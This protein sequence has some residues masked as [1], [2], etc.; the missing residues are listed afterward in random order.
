MV[1]SLSDKGKTHDL[2]FLLK[3]KNVYLEESGTLIF[4]SKEHIYLK[5]KIFKGGNFFS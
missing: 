5:V 4:F 1:S 3:E 2:P